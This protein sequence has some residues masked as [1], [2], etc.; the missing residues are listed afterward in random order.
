MFLL[1]FYHADVGRI[2]E[3][4]FR[5][6]GSFGWLEMQ[7]IQL[8]PE[9]EAN[10]LAT[11]GESMIFRKMFREFCMWGTGKQP[12]SSMGIARGSGEIKSTNASP[13]TVQLSIL[14]FDAIN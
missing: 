8:L 5:R 6:H 12:G 13:F 14:Y 11:N 4:V 7:D 10:H 2:A 3:F 9:G 1:R